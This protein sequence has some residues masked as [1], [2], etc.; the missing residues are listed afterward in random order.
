MHMNNYCTDLNLPISQPLKNPSVLNQTSNEPSIF[1]SDASDEFKKWLDYIGCVLTYPPLI[2]YTPP[3]QDC[4][5]HIDGNQISD[6]ATMNWIV[7]GESSLMHW[8]ELKDSTEITELEQTQ[9][10]T[11][12]TRYT[13][14]KV[15][16]VHSQVVTYPSIVQVGIPHNITNYGSEPRWCISCD[17]STKEK[18]TSGLTYQQALEIFKVWI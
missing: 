18:P 17:I 5:I 14:D 15:N 6:R 7:Q 3:G 1:W 4:G 8:Y 13:Q 12:Y 10:G 2:F 16:I 9:A 11:P